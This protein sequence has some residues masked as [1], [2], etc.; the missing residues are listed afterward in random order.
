M[1]NA[2]KLLNWWRSRMDRGR[3]RVPLGE[4]HGI[5]AHVRNALCG[6]MNAL[7]AGSA[8]RNLVA[9]LA[10]M[11]NTSVRQIQQ[12]YDVR[13]VQRQVEHFQKTQQPLYQASLLQ[14]AGA[15]EGEAA[16]GMAM[17][18]A[19]AAATPVAAPAMAA[20]QRRPR[21]P[22]LSSR[23]RRRPSRRPRL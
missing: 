12:H 6:T 23:S 20:R 18:T 8:E 16:A 4:L 2:N 5:A 1:D 11:M 14:A 13:H 17:A 9:P 3:Q 10:A 7:P 19:A 22:P 15:V 21:P